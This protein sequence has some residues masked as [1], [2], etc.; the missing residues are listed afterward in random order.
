M[1]RVVSPG[2]T[3]GPPTP[4]LRILSLPHFCRP[5]DRKITADVAVSIEKLVGMVYWGHQFDVGDDESE[6]GTSDEETGSEDES[7][8]ASDTPETGE[9]DQIEL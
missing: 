8:S 5:E 6:E 2:S 4:D 7:S 1:S 3:S 9:G